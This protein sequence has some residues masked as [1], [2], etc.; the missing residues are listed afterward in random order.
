MS[1]QPL[2]RIDLSP[3]D[4]SHRIDPKIYGHFL[5]SAFFGN[6][7]GGV[8][9]EG[10][11][12]S[13]RSD[14]PMDGCR[15]DVIDA[16]RDLGMPVVRWP[17][18]NF[19]SAYWWEDGTGPRDQRPRRLE[20]AWGS[21]ET[22]R[23]GTPEFLAWCEATG[24]TAYLAHGCRSVEDAVRWVEYCNYGG[25]TEMTRRR[26][27]D[28]IEGPRAV[29]IWGIGNEVY[30]P[31][32]MGHRSAE[33]YAADALDHAKFM[34]AVDGS[35]RFVC[36][37]LNDDRWMDVVVR[38]LGQITEWFSVHAY[39]ASFHLVDPSRAEFDAIVS[40]AVHFEQVLQG[41]SQKVAAAASR[42]G[43]TSPLEIAFDEW[44]MRHFE[45]RS[46]EEPQPGADGGIA[47]R[48][49]SGPA[50]A[51]GVAGE[52]G[53]RVSRYSPRT[54]A[55]ALF[56]SGVFHAL[57]RTAGNHVPVTMANTVNLVNAN[58]LLAVREGGMVR[59]AT[60]HVWDLYLNHFGTVPLPARVAG[61]SVTQPVR[62][63]QGWGGAAQCVEVRTSVGVLDVSA[64]ES[65]DG[66]RRYVAVINRSADED[67]EAVLGVN[68]ELIEG[69]VTV[70]TLGA[71]VQELFA[72]NTL[73]S[74][75]V[76][77]IRESSAELRG[78]VFVA[79]AHSVSV[80][81]WEVEEG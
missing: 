64:S 42:H 2:A 73:S 46:W 8:F 12:L 61:P 1:P 55:D 6:I 23:F 26:T 71:D 51:P 27:A 11:E 81:S 75:D 3:A 16:S 5:E 40:Q 9:D 25:D 52:N 38:E 7:E 29:P 15:Q 32:Q 67:V 10:S 66:S 17:G 36:V 62:H 68:G 56:Y 30:G 24:A 39:G 19:T 18:G 69:A 4:G 70:H 60:F 58:G 45:P 76:L 28:G 37:G 14:G 44:N 48:D 33:Q 63:E 59:S 54:L 49:T 72:V 74:P 35:I 53:W 77:G 65:A 57:H 20:L 21:E 50:D 79:P 34:R 41:F 78:G 47:P 80:V 22:N 31:W 13:V 43:I